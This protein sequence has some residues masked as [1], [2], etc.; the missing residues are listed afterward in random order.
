MEQS[1][2]TPNVTPLAADQNYSQISTLLG[3]SSSVLR[4][5]PVFQYLVFISYRFYVVK[6]PWSYTKY[7]WKYSCPSK[8]SSLPPCWQSTNQVKK[9]IPRLVKKGRVFT[10]TEHCDKVQWRMENVE[11]KKKEKL[12]KDRVRKKEEKNVYLK[13]NYWKKLKKQ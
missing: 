8:H 5:T 10:G 4:N 6:L 1:S 2:V 13:K 11:K 9:K 3:V 7:C 12:K